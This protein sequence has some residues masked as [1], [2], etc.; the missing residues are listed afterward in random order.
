MRKVKWNLKM[1]TRRLNLKSRKELLV[2][3]AGCKSSK[4]K[5]G[6]TD[7][8]RHALSAM[9]QGCDTASSLLGFMGRADQSSR[10]R[11]DAVRPLTSLV[12]LQMCCSTPIDLSS[13]NILVYN[14][15][16]HCSGC[17]NFNDDQIKV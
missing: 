5:V 12:A 14:S 4:T 13:F 6:G 11:Q 3:E 7:K 16:E 1:R 10:D 17:C 15:I 8:K 2:N 9:F